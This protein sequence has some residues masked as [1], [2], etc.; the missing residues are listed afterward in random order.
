MADKAK[1]KNSIAESIKKASSDGKDF[2]ALAKTT[3]GKTEIDRL[4]NT[5]NSDLMT[6]EELKIINDWALSMV[7]KYIRTKKLEN[8]QQD[9]GTLLIK[10]NLNF[11]D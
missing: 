1:F 11:K 3:R 8:I 10:Y 5:V 4:L 9:A 7:G 6:V 2:S